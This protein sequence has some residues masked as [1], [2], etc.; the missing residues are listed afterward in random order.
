MGSLHS[1]LYY[2]N[3]I[4]Q[5]KTFLL[6]LQK[7]LIYKNQKYQYVPKYFKIALSIFKIPLNRDFGQ[8]GW[9]YFK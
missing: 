6:S 7:K 3:L 2:F 1:L 8:D 4:D 9:N 5:A